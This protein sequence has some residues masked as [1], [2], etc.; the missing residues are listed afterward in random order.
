MRCLA[1]ADLH[2]SLPQFDW[3]LA[4][5]RH[6]DLI[7]IS[8]DLLE[9]SAT[10]DRRAQIVVIRKYLLKL[11][12][13]VPV[14]ICSGNHDLTGRGV[15]GEQVADWMDVLGEDGIVADGESM[16]AGGA[17]VT[18]CGWWDG[19]LT[20]AATDDH[21]ARDAAK[22]I[23]PWVWAYHAPPEGNPTAWSGSRHF[24]DPALA[25][26]IAQY[27]PD[28]VLAGHVHEAPFVSGGRWAG[29]VGRTWVF[30]PGR[31]I[32]A[33]PAHLVFDLKAAKAVWFSFDGAETVDLETSDDP[34]AISGLPAWLPQTMA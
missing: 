16:A 9:L 2:Y 19:P 6:F 24:G 31:Q 20:K 1:V 5:A 29:R 15:G 23:R 13:L 11:R 3:L 12:E 27:Q 14:V 26:W 8:G 32:G 34:V 17:L 22:N 21:L 10:V 18:A 7:I 33:L 4:E 25:G 28:V 30:N